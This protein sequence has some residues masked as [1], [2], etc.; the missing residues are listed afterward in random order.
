MISVL[1][2]SSCQVGWVVL[3]LCLSYLWGLFITLYI[4]IWPRGLSCRLGFIEF[5]FISSQCFDNLQT[6]PIQLLIQTF[7][8]SLTELHMNIKL[9]TTT[10]WMVLGLCL[11]HLWG[12]FKIY[13]VSIG[14]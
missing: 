3:N 9:K 2:N 6:K 13:D 7:L 12:L 8:H 14:R 1:D 10:V 11:S 5:V 4:S